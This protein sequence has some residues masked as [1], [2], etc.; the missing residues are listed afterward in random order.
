MNTPPG[1]ACIGI[2]DVNGKVS[3]RQGS[4]D[5]GGIGSK[6]DDGLWSSTDY[7]FYFIPVGGGKEAAA[8]GKRKET[9]DF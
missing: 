2:R 9:G 8:Y 3:R 1:K 4:H 6:Y 7:I 5:R